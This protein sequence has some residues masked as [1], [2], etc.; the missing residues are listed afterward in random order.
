MVRRSDPEERVLKT[1]LVLTPPLIL[2]LDEIKRVIGATS[3]SEAIRSL[4]REKHAQ[5]KGQGPQAADKSDIETS[6][7]RATAPQER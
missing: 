1:N 5:L 2:M 6:V 4:I 3:R 7:G